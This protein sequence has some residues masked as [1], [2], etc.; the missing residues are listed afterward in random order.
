MQVRLERGR[1]VHDSRTFVRSACTGEV[2]RTAELRCRAG[3]G[4]GH[5]ALKRTRIVRGYQ[6]EVRRVGALHAGIRSARGVHGV[7]GVAGRADHKRAREGGAAHSGATLE[8]VAVV[9]DELVIV[10]VDAGSVG[11]Y[12]RGANRAEGV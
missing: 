5:V 8:E 1:D 9:A 7:R 6:E 12:A 10:R 2:A 3:L 4:A 11:H